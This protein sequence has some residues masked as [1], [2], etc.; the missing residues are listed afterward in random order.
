VQTVKVFSE[1]KGGN[2]LAKSSCMM[3]WC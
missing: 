3:P 1:H 2:R